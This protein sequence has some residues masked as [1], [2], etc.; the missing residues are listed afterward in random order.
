MTAVRIGEDKK[1]SGRCLAPPTKTNL[2][3]TPISKR[4]NVTRLLIVH[5]CLI[6]VV[7]NSLMLKIWLTDCS[8][9][10][11]EEEGAH[12]NHLDQEEWGLVLPPKVIHT[13]MIL[14]TLKCKKA[15]RMGGLF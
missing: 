5:Q 3:L 14:G 12:Q 8:H 1:Q 15:S 2:Q 6:P 9:S 7:F 13:K 10:N 4:R 11:I